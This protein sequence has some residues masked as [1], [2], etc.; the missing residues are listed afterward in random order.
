MF[1]PLWLDCAD[2]KASIQITVHCLLPQCLGGQLLHQYSP[3]LIYDSDIITGLL[4]GLS[5]TRYPETHL[6]CLLQSVH[7]NPSSLSTARFSRGLK[8]TPD[9]LRP[10]NINLD[11]FLH[12]ASTEHC[13]T[14]NLAFNAALHCFQI[15][16]PLSVYLHID[17]KFFNDRSHHLQVIQPILY[18]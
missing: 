17:D 12:S 10:C 18:D 11:L 9:L 8:F 15:I 4:K 6:T 13:S 3:D 2:R 16:L 5:K 1:L 7:S 14:Y